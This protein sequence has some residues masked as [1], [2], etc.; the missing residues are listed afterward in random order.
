MGF[1]QTCTDIIFLE[2]ISDLTLVTLTLFSRTP[3]AIE[4]LG[5][6][7]RGKV[8]TISPE[9]DNGFDQAYT[10]TLLGRGKVVI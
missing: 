6:V 9:G 2:K 7:S 4:C 8:C 3:V 1:D 10:D 5:M